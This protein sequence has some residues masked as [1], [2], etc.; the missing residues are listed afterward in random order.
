[1]RVKIISNT[2]QSASKDH[3]LTDALP[4]KH[5]TIICVEPSRPPS[6]RE[7]HAAP[8]DTQKEAP[9]EHI[10]CRP[11][12]TI[13]KHRLATTSRLN[14]APS[15]TTSYHAS[16][17][18]HLAVR[19]PPL[20]HTQT[21]PPQVFPSHLLETP[22]SSAKTASAPYSVSLPCSHSKTPSDPCLKRKV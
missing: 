1:M 10:A 17:T 6:A 12:L 14:E 8:A 22:P 21:P 16:S 13:R 19:Q 4:Q 3:I 20:Q 18:C 15:N 5:L 9:P 2:K 7:L 11:Q